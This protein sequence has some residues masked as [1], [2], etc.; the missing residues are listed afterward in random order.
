MIPMLAA[1]AVFTDVVSAVVLQGLELDQRIVEDVVN[2]ADPVEAG[3][4]AAAVEAHALLSMEGVAGVNV[5]GLASGAGTRIAAH[6]KVGVRIR[7]G[8]AS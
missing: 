6:V 4:E 8:A 7:V 5:S 2:T 1:V 3:I